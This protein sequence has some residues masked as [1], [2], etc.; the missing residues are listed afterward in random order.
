[1]ELMRQHATDLATTFSVPERQQ[2]PPILTPVQLYAN[3]LQVWYAGDGTLMYVMKS[4]LP[5]V[6]PNSANLSYSGHDP[7]QEA[8]DEAVELFK[9]SLTKQ[10]C[11]QIWLKDKSSMM[12]VQRAITS[13]RDQYDQS[14]K[15]SKIRAWLTRCATRVGH[16]GNVMDVLIQGCPDYASFVWGALKFLFMVCIVGYFML[17][18][19]C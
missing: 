3:D 4:L 2:A 11:E 9:K 19:V 15:K 13:A 16:Y 18:F 1:M 14:A 10:E 5:R 8:F 17:T 7:A 12:D 6:N